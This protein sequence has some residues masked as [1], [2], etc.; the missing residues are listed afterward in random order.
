VWFHETRELFSNYVIISFLK[1]PSSSSS[2]SS[3]GR[4]PLGG[5]F[6]RGDDGYEGEERKSENIDM[7]EGSL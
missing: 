4:S 7:D 1:S 6:S 5:I 2:S 3:M